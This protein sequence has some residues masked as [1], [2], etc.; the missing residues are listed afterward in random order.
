MKEPLINLFSDTVTVPSQKMLDYMFKA[1][2]GDDVA[3]ADPTVKKLE[4]TLAQMF[5]HESALFFP[6]GTMTNQAAIKLQTQPGDQMICDKWSHVYNYEGGAAAAISGVTSTLIDGER[7]MFT[8]EQLKQK[9]NDKDDFHL[10][11]TRLITVENTTNKG[12]GACWDFN[13]LEKISKFCKKNEYKVHLDGAR[14]F[15]AIVESDKT[16][17]QYGK[18][19]NTISICLSKSLGAPIGSVLVSD[20]ATIVRAQRVRKLLGGGMR[21]VGYLAA[22]G[23]YALEN[24]IER[25]KI[26]HKNAQT[27]K[28]ALKQCSKVKKV[29]KVETNVVIFYLND[30]LCETEFMETLYKNNIEISDMGQGKLR[31]VTH[32]DITSS[33]IDY[34]CEVLQKI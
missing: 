6:S 24:N 10:P 28:Q 22:A 4:K 16:P 31:M 29:E 15:N 19:F 9:I 1:K 13:E 14:L 20:H 33:M 8:L 18:L 11:I 30:G 17:Q 32:L 23:I 5:G 34:V 12:G 7:G 25:L 2:V 21:Q 26:D 3:R 27:L